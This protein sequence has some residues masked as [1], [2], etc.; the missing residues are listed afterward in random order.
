M[1]YILDST[2][3]LYIQTSHRKLIHELELTQSLLMNINTFLASLSQH[4][5]S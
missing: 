4:A 1:K 5:T 2:D 3:Y